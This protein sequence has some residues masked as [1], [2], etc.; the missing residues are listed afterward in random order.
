MSLCIYFYRQFCLSNMHVARAAERIG[1]VQGSQEDWGGPGLLRGLGGPRAAKRI[2]GAQ[3]KYKKWGPEI[4]EILRA[5]KCVLGVSEAL[6]CACT[7]YIYT[8]Q[9]PS[10]ISCFRLKSTM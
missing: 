7:Q 3:G 10:L 6:F 2:G 5:L 4:F 1:G 8:C 9:L